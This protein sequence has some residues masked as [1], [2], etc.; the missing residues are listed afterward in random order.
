MASGYASLDRGDLEGADTAAARASALL[1][2][3]DLEPHARVGAKVL[4]A[5]GLRRRGRLEE[6]LA[7]LDDALQ[8]STEPGLLFPRR[9]ALS[10]RAGT[11]LDL[12]R[13]A[14]ALEAAREAV[15]TPS[16]DVRSKVLSLR[17]LGAALRASGRPE[18]GA[19]ALREALDVARST[20]Q[21]SEVLPTERLLRGAAG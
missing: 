13:V 10:H 4:L 11:L 5:Q 19:A 21:V 20:G 7:E 6:A 16:E 12:G 9:Q 3:L 1:G 17:A 2:G 8:A 15:A 14:E 18:E